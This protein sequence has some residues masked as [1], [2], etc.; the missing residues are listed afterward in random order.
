[1]NIKS[2]KTDATFAVLSL[3]LESN[4]RLPLHKSVKQEADNLEF[5]LGA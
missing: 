5:T 2:N 3:K 4:D 1:M